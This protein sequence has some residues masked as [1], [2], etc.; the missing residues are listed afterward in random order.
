M[1]DTP[2]PWH[3]RSITYVSVNPALPHLCPG[4]IDCSGAGPTP[5]CQ[6]S[7]STFSPSAKSSTSTSF[8]NLSVS[9]SSIFSNILLPSF[10]SA[11][12]KHTPDTV[13][14]VQTDTQNDVQPALLISITCLGTASAACTQT[15]GPGGYDE[16]G[17]NSGTLTPAMAPVVATITAGSFTPVESA[18]TTTSTSTATTETGSDNGGQATKT[19]AESGN[20]AGA[21][22]TASTGGVPTV[23]GAPGLML[24][25]VVAAMGAVL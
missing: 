19:G 13:S 21:T 2:T 9:D 25:G 7:V 20:D 10:P 14:S 22:D 3:R 6:G 11:K 15:R 23:T 5:E 4:L 17:T 18:S 1:Q 16:P 24:G 12:Q 8:S